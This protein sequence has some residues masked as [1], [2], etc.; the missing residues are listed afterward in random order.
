MWTGSIHSL[1]TRLLDQSRNGGNLL[2]RVREYGNTK[3]EA[4]QDAETADPRSVSLFIPSH[5]LNARQEVN[6]DIASTR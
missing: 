6:T 5:A 2:D 1:Q 3:L 4:L